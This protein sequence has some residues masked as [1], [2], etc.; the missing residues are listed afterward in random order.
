MTD[1]SPSPPA[2]HTQAPPHDG[3]ASELRERLARVEQRLDDQLP[4]LATKTWVLTGL[5]GGLVVVAGLVLAYL[6]LLL[7]P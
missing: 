6:K 4:H 1:G 2:R 7:V 3:G 5:L